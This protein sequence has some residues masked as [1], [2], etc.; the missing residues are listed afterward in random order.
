MPE[1]RVSVADEAG[2]VLG[3]MTVEIESGED[4]TVAIKAAASYLEWSDA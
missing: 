1:L 2:T 4:W 3:I